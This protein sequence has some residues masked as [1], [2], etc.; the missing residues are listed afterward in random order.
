MIFGRFTERAQIVLIE[1]QQESQKFKH[2][3]IGTEHV[4]LGI[5]KE[6]GYASQLLTTKGLTI[7]KVRGLTEEYLG[8]GDEEILSGDILL[9]PRTK[10]LFDDS[11]EVARKYGQNFITPEHILLSLIN[12]GEGVAY[13]ILT[14]CK[15]DINSMKDDLEKY[16]MGSE[17]KEVKKTASK[18]KK[19]NKTPML[20][21]FSRDLTQL[22]KD[23]KL[24][25]VVGRD[26]EKQRVLEILC[27]RVKNNPC[28]IGEPGV[29]KTAVI[30]G[31]AQRIVLGDIPESLKDKR[32]LTLDIT[33]MVAGAKYRGEFEDRLKKIMAELRQEED[34]IV[35][36]DEIHTIVGA[37]GAEGAID[38]SNILKP[39]LAR[40]E[41]KCIGATTIDEY[42]KH[43]EK[44]AALERISTSKY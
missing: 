7:D 36:I 10:R 39:A 41:I 32:I 6:N 2:G 17:L 31:L 30:E 37:G 22:A 20:D 23:Q 4:L 26:A 34:I 28:L 11:L 33:A 13:A 27:R 25:P 15:A 18:E 5:L 1:A 9:T 16:I 21:Q 3:Y 19:N 35:F 40:G 8:F 38:A 42:R 14:S 24:D 44:D 43:I 29:G 12:D